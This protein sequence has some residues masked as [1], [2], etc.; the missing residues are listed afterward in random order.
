MRFRLLLLIKGIDK[1]SII[2]SI[3]ANNKTINWQEF[4]KILNKK[5]IQFSKKL[6]NI[7]INFIGYD[8]FNKGN[9][10][11]KLISMI[12]NYTIPDEERMKTILAGKLKGK[13]ERLNN[14]KEID[15][16]NDIG[17]N[18]KEIDIELSQDEIDYLALLMYKKSKNIERLSIKSII[19]DL[20]HFSTESIKTLSESDVIN[21]DEATIIEVA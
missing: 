13:Y 18:L 9:A 12:P 10:I 1:R 14:L 4:E 7:L 20:I 2:N 15:K 16:I 6:T 5:Q 3:F 17:M 11:D 21:I 8:E 19:E